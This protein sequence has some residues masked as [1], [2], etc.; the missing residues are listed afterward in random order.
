MSYEIFIFRFDVDDVHDIHRRDDI[1]SPS[2]DWIDASDDRI[3]GGH[4]TG[5]AVHQFL[6]TLDPVDERETG[7]QPFTTDHLL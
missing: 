6:I 5:I 1:D 7:R 3:H 2:G 4:K